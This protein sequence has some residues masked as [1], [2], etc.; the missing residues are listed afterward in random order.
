MQTMRRIRQRFAALP[1]L[2][3]DTG[4]AILLIGI[5][6]ISFFENLQPILVGF[7][8]TAV[9]LILATNLPVALRR[10]YPMIVLIT[11]GLATFGQFVLASFEL[12]SHAWP[13][14]I[15]PYGLMVALYTVADY[16]PRR[17]SLAALGLVVGLTF[18]Q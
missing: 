11:I 13:I 12:L 10:R 7:S 14:M 15:N 9:G 5:F 16:R 2:A 8:P 4:L 1:A 18:L 3:V 6:L 17:T